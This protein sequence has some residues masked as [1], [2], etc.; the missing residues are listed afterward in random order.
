MHFMKI[1]TVY[2]LNS[3][4]HVLTLKA[5]NHKMYVFCRPLIYLKPNRQTVWTSLIWVHIVCFHAYVRCSYFAGV[6]RAK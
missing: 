6:L 3:H 4:L 2:T 5:P 1:L